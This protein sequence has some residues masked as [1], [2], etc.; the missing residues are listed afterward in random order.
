MKKRKV[1]APLFIAVNM[2]LGSIQPALAVMD[3]RP[4]LAPW[5]DQTEEA[6]TEQTVKDNLNGDGSDQEPENAVSQ[7]EISEEK[8]E[9]ED[10]VELNT[11]GTEM[12]TEEE[13]SED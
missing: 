9:S 4:V 1:L 13:K 8:I 10:A 7:E 5:Q 2:L 11:E 3:E 6:M 12:S